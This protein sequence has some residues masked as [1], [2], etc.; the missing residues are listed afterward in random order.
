[1]KEA[2]TAGCLIPVCL[3]EHLLKTFFIYTCASRLT[4]PPLPPSTE[5]IL[6]LF[7]RVCLVDAPH[8]SGCQFCESQMAQVWHEGCSSAL[9]EQRICS[10]ELRGACH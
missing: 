5:E 10:I 9:D 7:L 4:S 1:M 6:E 2:A 8:S 3:L